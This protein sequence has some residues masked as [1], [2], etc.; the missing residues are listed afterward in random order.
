MIGVY[1]T[2]GLGNQLFNYAVGR[3]L[4]IEHNTSLCL[5]IGG[6]LKSWSR[7]YQLN[8]YNIKAREVYQKKSIEELV[9][10]YDHRFAL[11]QDII[12][13]RNNIVLVGD[14]QSPKYFED[15]REI[16]IKDISLKKN[17]YWGN[18]TI[19]DTIKSKNS[20]CIHVRRGDYITRN[21]TN[22]NYGN[23]CTL[24]YYNLAVQYLNQRLI[25]PYYFVFSDD[26]DWVKKNVKLDCNYIVVEENKSRKHSKTEN[27]Y[28]LRNS[29]ALFKYLWQEKSVNDFELMRYCNH[30]IIAN[31][32]FSWWAAWIAENSDKIICCPSKWTNM[33]TPEESRFYNLLIPS[34]WIKIDPNQKTT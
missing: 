14:W 31:S 5:Y 2:G 24:D 25:N 28:F 16:L 30:F 6:Y 11:N 13:K 21:R 18:R 9:K 22:A 1:L 32:T 33:D 34:S 10:V 7:R 3:K 19:S 20:V 15:I 23:I 17:K 4:A 12:Q 27:N 8:T 26:P 29:M